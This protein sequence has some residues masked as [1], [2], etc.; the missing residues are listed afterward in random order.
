MVIYFYRTEKEYAFLLQTWKRKIS[1]RCATEL[2]AGLPTSHLRLPP[3]RLCYQDQT[4]P[5]TFCSVNW[6]SRSSAVGHS[7]SPLSWLLTDFSKT[8]KNYTIHPKNIRLILNTWFSKFI[9]RQKQA[10]ENP[11]KDSGLILISRPSCISLVNSSLSTIA[12]EV[13]Y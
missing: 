1:P 10:E 3:G 12:V 4:R 2:S 13:K 6:L 7:R 5:P 11:G 9:K 8:T